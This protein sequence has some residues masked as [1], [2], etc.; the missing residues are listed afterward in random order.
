MIIMPKSK[1]L[2]VEENP[3]DVKLLTDYMVNSNYETALAIDEHDVQEKVDI[4]HP[5]LI[6]LNIDTHK[7]DCFEF[8]KMIKAAP[9][10]KQIMILMLTALNEL[11]DIERAVAA[12]CDDF[13]SKPITE[14]ELLKRME[15]LLKIR[16]ILLKK[17]N[18]T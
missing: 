15:I 6:L 16:Y 1:I 5:D 3:T 2:I 11:G 4:F 7:F 12:G 9:A 10:T 8:C 17:N 14:L 13:L 18:F